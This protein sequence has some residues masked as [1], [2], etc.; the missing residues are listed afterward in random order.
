MNVERIQKALPVHPHSPN[1]RIHD[2]HE[3]AMHP[4]DH[5]KMRAAIRKPDD[6]NRWQAPRIFEEQTIRRDHGLRN[7]QA[8]RL[9]DTLESLYRSAV[10]VRLAGFP[11]AAIGEVNTKPAK[12]RFNDAG[13]QSIPDVCTTSGTKK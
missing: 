10:D 7:I 11:Q 12:K 4:P 13:P 3:R 9:R 6:N 5:D 8:K 2:L 1:G